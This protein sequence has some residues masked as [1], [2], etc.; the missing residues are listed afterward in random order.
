MK[1]RPLMCF[2]VITLFAALATP[3]RLAAGAVGVSLLAGAQP[4]G[5]KIVYVST[6]QKITSSYALDLRLLLVLR[7]S[8][9]GGGRSRR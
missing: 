7:A 4:A 3:L 8:R 9:C 1:S 6:N 5:A 2:T